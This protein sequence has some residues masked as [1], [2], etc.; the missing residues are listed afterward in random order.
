M[1]YR[2]LSDHCT[3]GVGIFDIH[4]VERD[5]QLRSMG[6]AARWLGNGA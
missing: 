1:G 2:D 3:F 6:A 4:I 5:G